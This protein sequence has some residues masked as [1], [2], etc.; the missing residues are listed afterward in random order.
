MH[1]KSLYQINATN[2]HV[3]E[4]L[5]FIIQSIFPGILTGENCICVGVIFKAW[6]KF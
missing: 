5:Q 4:D 2:N 1:L 3:T 6:S